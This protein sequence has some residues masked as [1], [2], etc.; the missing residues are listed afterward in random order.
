MKTRLNFGVIGAGMVSDMH[1]DAL[2]KSNRANVLWLADIEKN[3]LGRKMKKF[4]IPNGTFDYHDILNDDRVDAVV[5]AV[6]PYLHFEVALAVL[7]A[8]KNLLLEKPFVI[9]RS[10]MNRL[11]KE[12]Q[13]H[14]NLV[15]MECS[16]RHARLQ[17]KFHY[18]RKLI[19]DGAI[20]DV[21]HI[22]HN[23]LM[24]R[25]FIEYNPRG[26]WAL[27]KSLAG[28]GPVFDW[29]V[30]DL[31]FH[32]GLLHDVPKLNKLCS[33][34]KNNIKIYS[35][36]KI[37]SDVEQHFAAYMEFDRGLSYYYERGSGVHC[38]VDNQTRILGTK[39]SLRFE[40]CSWDSPQIEYF[41]VNKN[42]VEKKAVLKVDMSKHP[43]DHPALVNHFLNCL[44]GKSKPLMPVSLAA[45]H[46]DILLKILHL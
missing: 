27:K 8:Q 37:K 17:P 40:Y 41:W 23:R 15:I 35:D 12:V 32:L 19:D 28:A 3:I 29:G 24:R 9:N 31:S 16:A 22:H 33:F 25:T 45:K 21:Y 14:K 18:I 30:Y 20:G 10:Q 2:Q 36:P 1:I 34:D 42:R 38:E 7:K 11:T 4:N 46:L 5:V 26:T 13:K 44:D 6:P 39:G 43:G